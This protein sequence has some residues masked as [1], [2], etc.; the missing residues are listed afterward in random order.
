MQHS[1]F[2]VYCVILLLNMQS[3]FKRAFYSRTFILK[4]KDLNW[5]QMSCVHL[6]ILRFYHTNCTKIAITCAF[7]YYMKESLFLHKQFTKYIWSMLFFTWSYNAQFIFFSSCLY[8]SFREKHAESTFIKVLEW[9]MG[10]YYPRLI[11]LVLTSWS[12]V[13]GVHLNSFNY[14]HVLNTPT[15][16]SFQNR[17]V[18]SLRP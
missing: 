9:F 18:G 15:S 13:L 5:K 17:S 2:K 11:G 14:L 6:Q 10:Y 8:I 16:L 4:K 7:V 12:L 1:T 3:L